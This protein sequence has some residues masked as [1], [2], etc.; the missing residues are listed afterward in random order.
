MQFRNKTR[1]CPMTPPPMDF[2]PPLSLLLP[3][4]LV[5][6]GSIRLAAGQHLL[7]HCIVQIIQG[8]LR[9]SSKTIHPNLIV[10]CD[11]TL[12]EC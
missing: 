8:R 9:D 10:I 4:P 1:L 11:L 2:P 6:V 12:T 5:Q 3:A 7:L